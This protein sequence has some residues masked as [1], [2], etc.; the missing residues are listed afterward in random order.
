VSSRTAEEWKSR[1]IYQILTDRFARTDNSIEDC[2]D[3]TNYCGGTFKGIQNNLDYIQGMGFDAIWISPVNAN[4]QAGKNKEWTTNTGGYHGYWT[5]NFYE[6]NEKFGTA[7]ELKELIDACH[8]RDIWVMV[9]VIGN[10][11]GYVDW[12]DWP[13][14]SPSFASIVPFNDPSY[15]NPYLP[16]ETIDWKNQTAVELCWLLGLPDL[17]QN[18]PFVKE[19]LLNWARD[20]VQTY[21]LDALRIDTVLHVP[22]QFWVDFGKAAGVFCV[23]EL[24]NLDMNYLASYQGTVDSVL[25]YPLYSTLRN[26]FQAGGSMKLME[27]YYKDA[28]VTWP[29]IT[30]LGNFVDNHDNHRF[31]NITQDIEAFKSALGFSITSVGIPMVY[32]GDE[33]AFSGGQDPYNRETLWPNMNT[34]SDIY[35]FLHAVNSFRKTTEFYKYDQIQRHVDEHFYAFSR[36]DYLFAFA[37]SPA[38]Q[39]QTITSH[40]YS[41][42]T[43][44]C[45][46][47]EKGDCVEV[48]NGEFTVVMINGKMKI[49]APSQ[50]ENEDGKG[51]VSAWNQIKAGLATGTAYGAEGSQIRE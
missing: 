1:S 49:Y 26:T 50:A 12:P 24:F 43:Q 16:C 18:N 29:D 41:E 10:H 8:E 11:V 33:H 22:K 31:L 51:Q 35:K 48:K 21:N 7:E 28:Y 15:Y 9:D 40:S 30:T 23:G 6:I 13:N 39:T 5:S 14:G 37:N 25:N 32:Y 46:V 44:L 42:G 45:N 2:K 17:D 34:D 4:T 38:P 3:I 36:G 27:D 19:T 20:L 47:L